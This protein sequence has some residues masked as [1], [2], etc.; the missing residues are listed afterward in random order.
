[1]GSGFEVLMPLLCAGHFWRHGDKYAVGLMLVW[2]GQAITSV[3]V[4]AGDAIVQQ[5]ELLGGN[6]NVIHDW[7]WMLVDLGLLAYTLPPALGL[8]VV[9]WLVA[10]VGVVVAMWACVRT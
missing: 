1:M 9:G 5:L 7:N 4:Y 8:Y 3:S 10:G 6:E 2:A